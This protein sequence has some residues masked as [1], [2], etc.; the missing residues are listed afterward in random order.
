MKKSSYLALGVL[1]IAL[2]FSACKK[3]KKDETTPAENKAPEVTLTFPTTDWKVFTSG[4]STV[5]LKATASDSDGSITKVEFYSGET[6]IG[7]STSSP[8]TF[9]YPLTVDVTYYIKAVATDDKGKTAT[10][11]T[12]KATLIHN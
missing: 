5:V 6:K 7:E 2:L 4:D 11:T 1:S 12:N 10:S 3:D 9:S 8:Y